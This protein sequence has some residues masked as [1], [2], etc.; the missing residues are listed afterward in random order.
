MKIA[1]TLTVLLVASVSLG[2]DAAI[3]YRAEIAPVFNKYCNGC[4]NAAD[5]EGKLALD[6]YSSVLKGGE[7][8][9]VL[10][11][12]NSAKS[13]LIQVLTGAAKPAMPPDDNEKPTAAEIAL[14]ARWI[15]AGA[16]GPSGDVV[17]PPAL[18]TPKIPVKGMAKDPVSAVAFFPDG[19]H[20]AVARYGGVERVAL[21]DRSVL[22]RIT[23]H[24]GRVNGLSFSQDGKRLVT[25]A[26]EPGLFG[27]TRLWD[28]ATGALLQT[29]RGHGDS[30][31]AAVLSPDG[32]L[33]A[34]SSYDQQI[35]L[36]DTATGKEIR[37]LSG[38]N[39]AV[40]ELAFRPDGKILASASG[41]RTVKLWKVATGERL[42]TLGQ[43]LKDLYTV[44]FS[45]DGKRVAAGGIDNRIRVWEVTPDA[46]ENSN[47]LL[48][49]K[50]AHEGAIIKVLFSRDGK[51]LVS[52]SDDR[53][54]KI[55]TGDTVNERL[56]LER[57]PDWTPA[58]AL[59]PDGKTLVA[60][61][62]DGSL[63][64]YDVATGKLA[65]P[66]M[67]AKPEL[68]GLSVRGWQRG[69]SGAIKLLGKNLTGVTAIKT[70]HP[71][72]TASLVPGGWN[73]G[74]EL[75][76]E[77]NVAADVPPGAYEVW[78]VSPGGETSKVSLLVD[79]L[80]QV[81]EVE[82][83][84]ART[85]AQSLPAAAS[86]WGVLSQKGDVDSFRF[87]GQKGQAIVLEVAAASVGSKLN[88]IL[89]L[90]D[91][92]GRVLAG[93]NDFDSQA[94]PLVAYSLPA[95]G[96]YVVQIADLAL[97]G[98]AENYYRLTVSTLPFV[99]AVFPAHVPSGR[100]VQVELA[101]LNVPPGAKVAIP[102][103]AGGEV[104][105]P[106]D[107]QQF[108]ARKALE[109]MVGGPHEQ[110]ET[111]PNGAPATAN[112]LTIPGSINGRVWSQNAGGG[113]DDLYRFSAK[114]GHTW[115]IETEAARRGSPVD[116]AIEVLHTDGKP[117]ERLLLEANRD[118]QVTFRPID[119]NIRDVRVSNWQEM[120]LN[121]YLFMNGEICKIFRLPQGPDSGFQFY[122]GDGGKR[123]C[124]FE[125]SP[126]IHALD[127][128]CYIVTPLPPGSRPSTSGLPVFRL[129]FANDDDGERKLGSDSRVTFIAPQDGDY[130]I[131]V[132][133]TRGASGDRF[134]YRLTVR[135]PKPDFN[136]T[137][138]NVNP[139]VEPGSGKPFTLS[140]D[141]ID[142]FDGEIKVDITGLPP[143]F[144]V[145]GPIFIQA[146]HRDAKGVI[147]A[148]ASAPAPTAAN[149]SQTVLKATATIGGKPV[150]KDVNNLGAIKLG[151][152][153]KLVVH[154]EPAEITIAPGQMV[155]ATLR[156]ERHGH[157]D[158]VNFTVEGLP[159][160]VFV[161]NLGLNGVLL[162]KGQT[163][164]QIFLS[165][166]SWVTDVDRTCFGLATNAGVQASTPV[167]LKVRKPSPLAD[168]TGTKE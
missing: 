72:V 26:G 90:F 49:S 132:R 67:A 154:L 81:A 123:R 61:R 31:Y 98:S 158:L 153:P 25:A 70:N 6:A 145:N 119:S 163:E 18:V 60:G 56:A 9:A 125:T 120:E 76:A 66:T 121:E 157:D 29:F 1:T 44:D 77:L 34:T 14:L 55:W 104:T 12:G 113:D 96:D 130:L 63:A 126:T 20:L 62:A 151:A 93:N 19:A 116:T 24:Q 15:D 80:A 28:A 52:A 3:D 64:V 38:H 109:V 41:D 51:T 94:D 11:A 40:F 139:A 124:Y 48:L 161:E 114:A 141:R 84:D 37:T 103:A 100:A 156:V 87:A 46:K 57:Q 128:A 33:A 2:A 42:D 8:G 5:R 50:F 4:H 155:T 58:L 149:A 27:E 134:L 10:V 122:E 86:V 54:I 16:K 97:A 150:T 74:N 107:A 17:D 68:A 82:P 7:H 59:S 137:L 166:V 160:G 92:Q 162:P 146:G 30:I 39:D 127:E 88:A 144:H 129:S 99:T 147:Y 43:S 36:W 91:S 168:A 140:A 131:R 164:R 23:G 101:G 108:R 152:K 159:H 83:N 102:A 110:N 78:A 89:T 69:Q 135:E 79:T 148:D 22:G 133:D 75:A 53:T 85:A 106:I 71:K 115:I 21:A 35:K 138:G 73:Q 167:L 143:G 47:P 118:S 142:G 13:K 165:A 45:P 95:D 111:E 117:V 65:Q 32:K 112:G 105:V 136:V